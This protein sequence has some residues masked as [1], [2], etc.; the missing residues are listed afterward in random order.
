MTIFIGSRYENE[1]VTSLR[2]PRDRSMRETVFATRSMP[3]SDSTLYHLWTETDRMDRVAERYLFDTDRWW[4]IMDANPEI[5]CPF[6]L[7]PG[8]VIKVPNG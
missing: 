7:V 2:N 8:Q 4:E 6:D 5:L 3:V 1:R